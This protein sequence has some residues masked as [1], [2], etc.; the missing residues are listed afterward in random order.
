MF[1]KYR[2]VIATILVF[3]LLGSLTCAVEYKPSAETGLAE[4]AKSVEQ[5]GVM[6]DSYIIGKDKEECRKIY[7][8]DGVFCTPDSAAQ[9]NDVF[10]KVE[11]KKDCVGVGLTNSKGNLCLDEEQ[12]DLLITRG[13]N[14]SSGPA[15]IGS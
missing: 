3:I 15:E 6:N 4:T 14:M 7:G 11:G 5:F 9:T 2:I 8:F 12:K 10:G 13:G 1:N